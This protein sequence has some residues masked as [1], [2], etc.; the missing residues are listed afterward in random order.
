MPILL[1][2]LKNES[3]HFRMNSIGS[4]SSDFSKLGSESRRMQITERC[5]KREEVSVS[6]ELFNGC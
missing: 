1:N 4:K 2:D 5:W 6:N 3:M